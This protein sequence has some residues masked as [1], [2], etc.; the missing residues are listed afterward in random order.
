MGTWTGEAAN[1]S[2]MELR[3]TGWADG[4]IAAAVVFVTGATTRSFPVTGSYDVETG[5][6][7]LTGGNLTVAARVTGPTVTGTYRQGNGKPLPFT[8]ARP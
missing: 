4:Q 5:A 6:L 3:F 1:R 2:P 7:Q 8:A